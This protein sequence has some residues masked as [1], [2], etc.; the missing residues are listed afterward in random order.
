[1]T[2]QILV[3]YTH[4]DPAAFRAAFDADAEDR[5]NAGLTLL[6]LWR[7]GTGTAWALYQSANP[8]R[9]RETVDA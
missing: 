2:T 7:E 3:R 6:Q 5:G 1:M 9:A 4:A 8:A